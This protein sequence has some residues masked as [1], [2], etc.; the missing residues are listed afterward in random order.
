MV[1]IR[2]V[3]QLNAFTQWW[4]LAWIYHRLTY[5][6][7]SIFTAS[8]TLNWLCPSAY[9]SPILL[10][11]SIQRNVISSLIERASAIY[12]P[13]IRCHNIYAKECNTSLIIFCWIALVNMKT[14][15]ALFFS[16]FEFE[17]RVIFILF[18]KLTEFDKVKRCSTSFNWTIQQLTIACV[19]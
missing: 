10:F 1:N 11:V 16:Q 6:F 8:Q 15:R 12:Y 5:A 17:W 19:A 7:W 4:K 9:A 2:A 14:Q 18:C 13:F 3:C